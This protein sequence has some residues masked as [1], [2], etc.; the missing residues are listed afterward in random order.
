MQCLPLPSS[1]HEFLGGFR[2]GSARAWD[3][4]AVVSE[5]AVRWVMLPGDIH[6]CR[7]VLDTALRTGEDEGCDVL[8]QVGD[9]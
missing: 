9:F 6:N 4:D 5:A 7:Q 1:D 2:I 3:D 8:V